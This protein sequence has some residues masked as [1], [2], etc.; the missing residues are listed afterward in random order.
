MILV[1]HRAWMMPMRREEPEGERRLVR[2]GGVRLDGGVC[3][4]VLFRFAEA[5]DLCHFCFERWYSVWKRIM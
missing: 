5:F 3:T 2:G 1:F 4:V